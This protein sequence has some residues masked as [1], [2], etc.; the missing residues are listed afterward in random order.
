MM[1]NQ[2]N[3]KLKD[4]LRLTSLSKDSKFDR[5]SKSLTKKS[6]KAEPNNNNLLGVSQKS[7]LEE[8]MSKSRSFIE[9]SK[10]PIDTERSI[11]LIKASLKKK[12]DNAM[13]IS[14]NLFK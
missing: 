10:S 8:D 5:Y 11:E 3:L 4:Y 1:V 14:Y 13:K 7:Y 2:K 12:L 9:K 6:I